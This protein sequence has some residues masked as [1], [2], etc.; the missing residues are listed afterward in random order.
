[1]IKGHPRPLAL[2][3]DSFYIWFDIFREAELPQ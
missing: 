3:A 2:I 1:M